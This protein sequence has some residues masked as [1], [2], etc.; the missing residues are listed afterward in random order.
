MTHDKDRFLKVVD[1]IKGHVYSS[2][3]I[4]SVIYD[5]LYSINKSYVENHVLFYKS[6]SVIYNKTYEKFTP[7]SINTSPPSKLK[8][9]IYSIQQL[10]E[11]KNIFYQ[12]RGK[13]ILELNSYYLSRNKKSTTFLFGD[14]SL[15]KKDLET[16]KETETLISPATPTVAPALTPTKRKKSK[17]SKKKNV[18][19][20][21]EQEQIN[22]TPEET[23]EKKPCS[24]K[25]LVL[26]KAKKVK[27][28]NYERLYGKNIYDILNKNIRLTP[29]SES[30]ENT[31]LISQYKVKNI[32]FR[33]V[34]N[35]NND[36]IINDDKC[37][38]VAATKDCIYVNTTA[39][40]FLKPS[41]Y[42]EDVIYN[43]LL[44]SFNLLGGKN[45]IIQEMSYIYNK[46][47]KRQRIETVIDKMVIPVLLILYKSLPP[48]PVLDP[49]LIIQCMRK[50][51]SQEI[52]AMFMSIFCQ[53][54]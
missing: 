2:D 8:K 23:V 5:K 15:E 48:F 13:K 30:K 51:I 44:S 17:T 42:K 24:E 19:V 3:V 50:I 45:I 46:S 32:F 10:M 20:T 27:K 31:D 4:P 49:A 41:A 33:S 34:Y 14:C 47:T 43:I 29:P 18:S 28:V 37:I 54:N 21:R 6:H 16:S 7:Y 38:S 52:N 35:T 12:L 22:I 36:D 53:M 11:D 40:H 1:L 25:A 39:P 9:G 26:K